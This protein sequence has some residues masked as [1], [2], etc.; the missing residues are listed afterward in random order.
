MVAAALIRKVFCLNVFVVHQDSF[1][2]FYQPLSLSSFFIVF[3][4][5][6]ALFIIIEFGAY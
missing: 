2:K 1:R 3:S 6:I 4:Y 5:Y